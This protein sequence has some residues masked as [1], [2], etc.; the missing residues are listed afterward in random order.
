MRGFG[1][2]FDNRFFW[3]RICDDRE[4]RRPY[5]REGGGVFLDRDRLNAEVA[6]RGLTKGDTVLSVATGKIS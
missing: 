5:A 4:H 3:R 1:L 6:E 2:H